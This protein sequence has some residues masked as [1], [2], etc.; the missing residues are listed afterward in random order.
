MTMDSAH[1]P[2]SPSL[3]LI[4]LLLILGLLVLV[5]LTLYLRP[6]TVVQ[7]R[8]AVVTTT[9]RVLSTGVHMHLNPFGEQPRTYN[10]S[11][12]DKGENAGK[13]PAPAATAA[14]AAL[15]AGGG[16]TT[17]AA[18]TATTASL[19]THLSLSLSIMVLR[20][21]RVTSSDEQVVTMSASCFWRVSDPLLAVDCDAPAILRRCVQIALAREA[22]QFTAAQLAASVSLN[23]ILPQCV[24]KDLAETDAG[25]E[26]EDVKILSVE[27]LENMIAMDTVEN[28]RI[29]TAAAMNHAAMGGRTGP[30]TIGKT[31]GLNLGL[32]SPQG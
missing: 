6:F 8:Q 7:E 13:S 19:P 12:V 9:G 31:A 29:F 1:L 16:T 18:T 3:M 24:S 11:P 14:A 10:W 17:P 5:A 32:G 30:A 2:F 23:A 26:V 25:V 15:R 22:V 28:R 4:P 20:G 27:P 21:E